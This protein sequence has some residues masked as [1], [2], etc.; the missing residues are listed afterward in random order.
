MRGSDPADCGGSSSRWQGSGALWAC[1]MLLIPGAVEAR[2]LEPLQKSSCTLPESLAGTGGHVLVRYTVNEAGKVNYVTPA[3]SVADPPDKLGALVESVQAC[4]KGW[5]YRPVKVSQPQHMVSGNPTGSVQLLQAF[6]YFRPDL[7]DTQTVEIEGGKR[8][9]R[10]QL[11]EMRSLKLALG[12]K[13]LEGS[14]RVVKE[15]PGWTVETNAAPKER[16]V[17]VGGVMFAMDSFGK[18]FTTAR[19]LPESAKFTMLLF[20]EQDQFRQVAAFDN[21]FRGPTPAGQYTSWDMMAY[22]FSSGREHPVKMS[23]DYVVHETVHHLVF[24]RLGDEKRKPPFWVNEGIA[25]YFELL[26]PDRKGVFDLYEFRRGRQVEGGYSWV[27]K[28]DR[29]LLTFEE[30]L[31]EGR[32]PD[33]G[34][35]LDGSLDTLDAD[36]AY[37]LSWILTH[38][39]I[40]GENAALR[41]AWETWLTGGMGSDGDGGIPVALGRTTAQILEGIKGH[42][43]EMKRSG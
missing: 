40:N 19:P 39:L 29:Y 8:A 18:V 41:R 6:H 11:D 33:L 24:Q 10:K 14:Q 30:H 17:L 32:L 1:L 43:T 38:Y 27:S 13:L 34:K 20:G 26:E 23:R 22:T 12:R 2:Q 5:S 31:K 3:F 35:F 7:T 42:V 36:L 21:L 25:T 37:G 28:A 4:V 15:G 9:L 16:A